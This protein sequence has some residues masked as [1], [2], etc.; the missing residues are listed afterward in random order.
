MNFCYFQKICPKNVGKKLLHTA[1]KTGID[2][3][4][5]SSKKVVHKATEATGIN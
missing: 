2:A 3:A 1:T 4:K 5:I